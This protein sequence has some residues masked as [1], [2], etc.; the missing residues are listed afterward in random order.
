VLALAQIL[1]F[2]NVFL[3]ISGPKAR[4]APAHA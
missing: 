3:T 1:F 4:P 2:L